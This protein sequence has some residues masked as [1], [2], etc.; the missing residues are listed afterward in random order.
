M[1]LDNIVL[2][3]CFGAVFAGIIGVSSCELLQTIKENKFNKSYRNLAQK[4]ADINGDGVV[5]EVERNGFNDLWLRYK[6]VVHESGE[7]PKYK[8][9]SD[10]PL[11]TLAKWLKDYDK[12]KLEI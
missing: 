9:G 10:V 11:D 2:G 7:W 3:F 1:K 8:N 5:S 4:H 12:A 6:N